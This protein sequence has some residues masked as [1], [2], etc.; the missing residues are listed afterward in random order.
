MPDLAY[1]RGRWIATGEDG[2]IAAVGESLEE[3]RRFAVQARPRSR[4]ALAWVSPYPPHVMLPE[5]PL[6]PLQAI[7]FDARIW[8]A[9][10]PVRD[11]VLGRSPHDWDFVTDGSG[12]RLARAVADALGG[13]YYALDTERGT[14]RALIDR[15]GSPHPITLDFAQL[16]APTIEGDLWRRDF[17]VNAMALTL[18]GQLLDPTG[19]RFDLETH[20]LRMTTPT[21]FEDD[22]A[23]LL[24]AVRLAT[25]FA[26][27]LEAETAAR[28]R[29]QTQL[30][31]KIAPERIRQE[32]VKLLADPR[33]QLGL[34]H[35]LNLDLLAF[36]LPELVDAPALGEPADCQ[37]P[38]LGRSEDASALVSTLHALDGLLHGEQA[39]PAAGNPRGAPPAWA[40]DALSHTLAQQ[41]RGL[42]TYLY[43]PVSD[44]VTRSDLLKWSALFCSFSTDDQGPVS[45]QSAETR[46]RALRFS[47]SSIDFTAKLLRHLPHFSAL[48]TGISTS[49]GAA[50]PDREIY[51]YYRSAG[52]A[53][54][55]VVLVA[56][57]RLLVIQGHGLDRGDWMRHLAAGATLLEA[58]FERYDAVISPPR[59]LTGRDL[60]QLGLPQGPALGQT[61]ELLRE[62]Q[63]AGD[64][65]DQA[66]ALAYVRHH[67]QTLHPP[68][69]TTGACYEAC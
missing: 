2:G 30:I 18:D 42:L 60:M 22:P 62:A 64:V 26:F 41:Q 65:I 57:A 43:E 6:T 59:L 46:L 31:Q 13:A 69:D 4:L 17:T 8:L 52:D 35:L 50:I 33:A 16:R 48:A 27:T 56:L 34:Q 11:L 47:G 7:R 9:G 20:T 5:W 49:P 1:Y 61:L 14:G 40:W 25:Q 28:L 55:A 44:E 58:Y 39:P 12:L 63:A 68:G 23:R 66:E 15:P 3:T 54:V 19:G 37:P 29:S 10:G 51:R 32:L 38:R 45:W 21:S 67:A 36:I 53:G 24:R